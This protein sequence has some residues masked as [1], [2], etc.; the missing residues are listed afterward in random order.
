[1]V[2]LCELQMSKLC[3]VRWSS[4][5]KRLAAT[6]SRS[7]LRK[8]RR[9]C[10]ASAPRETGGILVGSYNEARTMAIITD[11]VS[12]TTDSLSTPNSFRRG[13]EGLPAMLSQ[14][15]GKNRYYLGEWHFHPSAS[16][17]PSRQDVA[18]MYD[19]ATDANYRCANPIMLIVGGGR[20]RWRYS[21][22]VVEDEMLVELHKQGW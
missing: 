18:Q 22:H 12:A 13:V 15:W 4:P 8:L 17:Q 7:L 5:D 1:M 20:R 10:V 21:L 19:I 2:L 9:L 11:V 3:E 14:I 6:I 16:P